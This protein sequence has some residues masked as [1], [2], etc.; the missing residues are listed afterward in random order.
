MKLLLDE[1]ISHVVADQV[2]G[3]G[4]R[5]AIESVHTWLGGTF[6]GRSDRELI[7]AA[8]EDG[9]TVVTYDLRSM[10]VLLVELANEGRS[11]AGVIFV[12]DLTIPNGDIGLL[13]RALIVFHDRFL[14]FD[15]ANRVHFLDRPTA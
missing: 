8:A 13:T 14:D 3:H 2:R 12:D 10:P 7:S 5:I 1:N 9:W 15:W 11:H 4:P 6:R